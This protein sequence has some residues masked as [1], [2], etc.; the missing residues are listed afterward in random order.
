MEI[1]RKKGAN[2]YATN[3]AKHNALSLAISTGDTVTVE[4]L[5][6][7]GDKWAEQGKAV[8]LYSVAAKYRRT[9]MADILKKQ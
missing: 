7:N 9:E 8:N 4:Y 5:L 2:I 1:L 3:N 6:R